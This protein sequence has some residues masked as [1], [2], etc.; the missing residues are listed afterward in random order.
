MCTALGKVDE[1]QEDTLELA[2]FNIDAASQML[3]IPQLFFITVPQNL[4]KKFEDVHGVL[5]QPTAK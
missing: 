2:A 4:W 1:V 5:A 3:L